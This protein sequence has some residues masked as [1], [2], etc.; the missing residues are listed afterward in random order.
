[1]TSVQTGKEAVA[2]VRA[3]RYD[4]VLMDVQ[5]PVMDGLQATRTIR[6][7]ENGTDRHTPIIAMTAHALDSDRDACLAAGMDDYVAKPLRAN[8][9]T[10]AL[11]RAVPSATPPVTGSI[12]IGPAPSRPAGS[13]V[14]QGSAHGG[15]DSGERAEHDGGDVATRRLD[16]AMLLEE[17]GGDS[18][19]LRRLANEFTAQ[20][21]TLRASLA[22]A[23]EHGDTD[24]L[25]DAAHALKGAVGFWQPD[26]SAYAAAR[27]LEA[28]AAQGGGD[29]ARAHADVIERE[30][31][32][33][34]LEIENL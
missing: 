18:A 1:V 22:R 19:L 3:D 27:S 31:E 13:Q 33:L 8:E 6:E 32:M 30:V 25:R 26:G 23:I 7:L 2:A 9:L 12:A 24:A 10:A 5:M 20:Y 28:L 21:E 17:A 29:A 4:A 15:A 16:T 34:L 11:L 14:G